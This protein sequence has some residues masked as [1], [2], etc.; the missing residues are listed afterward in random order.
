MQHFYE[1]RELPM[2]QKA[3]T[4]G[5]MFESYE[6]ED[7]IQE[8]QRK[9]LRTFLILFMMPFLIMV[10]VFLLGEVVY[11]IWFSRKIF[12]TINYL[13]EKIDML[14]KQHNAHKK[15]K[16]QLDDGIESARK[17]STSSR[18]GSIRM[19]HAKVETA[20]VVNVLQ[21]YEGRESCMEV[22]KLYRA[23]NKL[24]KTLTLARTSMVQGNENTA[25]LNYNEVAY[26]FTEKTANATGQTSLNNTELSINLDGTKNISQNSSGSLVSNNLGI[27][28][29]N[30]A[31][32]YAKKGNVV[33]MKHFFKESI[34]IEEQIIFQNKIKQNFTSVEENVKLGFRFFNFGYSLYHIT[35]KLVKKPNSPCKNLV[36]YIW[37]FSD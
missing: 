17:L 29:N 25:L 5:V 14:N 37:C 33:R 13:Y 30:I 11:I 36:Q 24:I 19:L 35:I 34:K 15:P 18:S 32:I 26:L 7:K 27:C 4:L 8:I 9:F 28:Y 21:D 1:N 3:Y 2:R 20:P 16:I 10:C 31:C 22:T 12:N 23:A 6:I